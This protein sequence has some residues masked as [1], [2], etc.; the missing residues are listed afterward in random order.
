M[1]W[2]MS[3]YGHESSTDGQIKDPQQSED[4]PEDFNELRVKEVDG[5]VEA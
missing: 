2:A 3:A 1:D 5:L 4:L